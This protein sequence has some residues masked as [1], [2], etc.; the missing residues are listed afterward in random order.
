MLGKCTKVSVSGVQV[1]IH[2][3]TLIYVSEYFD[4]TY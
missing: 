3:K 1:G 4:M 2:I